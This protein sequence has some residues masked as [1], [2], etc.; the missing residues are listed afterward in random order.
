MLGE[1]RGGGSRKHPKTGWQ[2][3]DPW[4][5][6]RSLVQTP[7]LSKVG[8][9]GDAAWLGCA[10]S[11]SSGHQ[12]QC[13]P[14]HQMVALLSRG[15]PQLQSL[16]RGASARGRCSRHTTLTGSGARSS[17]RRPPRSPA[18]LYRCR[19]GWSTVMGML[20]FRWG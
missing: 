15:V 14:W 13:S 19:A 8:G 6:K 11:G 1:E 17:W 7:E 12:P 9:D 20:K 16:L 4:G 10:V 18:W 2:V 5:L 3:R